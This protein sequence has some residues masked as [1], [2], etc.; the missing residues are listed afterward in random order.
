[1]NSSPTSRD[2]DGKQ[3][4]EPQF[5]GTPIALLTAAG[6]AIRTERRRGCP[7]SEALFRGAKRDVKLRDKD[8]ARTNEADSIAHDLLKPVPARPGRGNL[9]ALTC[10]RLDGRVGVTRLAGGTRG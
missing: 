1:M 6:Q 8:R 9:D 7:T 2:Q 3:L 10:H 5:P 4:A